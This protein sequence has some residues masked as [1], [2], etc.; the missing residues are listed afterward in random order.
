MVLLGLAWAPYSCTKLGLRHLR[1]WAC[2][3]SPCRWARDPLTQITDLAF[4]GHQFGKEWEPG[5][6]VLSPRLHEC[7]ASL[8]FHSVSQ[9]KSQGPPGSELRNRLH[10]SMDGAA[11]PQYNRLGTHAGRCFANKLQ[12][13]M[14][15]NLKQTLSPPHICGIPCLPRAPAKPLHGSLIPILLSAVRPPCT[16]CELFKTPM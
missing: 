12:K 5:C 10:L 14:N 15:E 8:P 9:S 2:R 6:E 3:A 4:N 11:A 7:T 1:G 16:A 13:V